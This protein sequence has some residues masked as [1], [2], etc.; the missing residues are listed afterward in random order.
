MN[1]KAKGKEGKGETGKLIKARQGQGKEE[2]ERGWEGQQIN[3]MMNDA[4]EDVM[5]N[6]KGRITNNISNEIMQMK[7]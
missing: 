2:R 7:D 6:E 5:N 4:Q 3:G 1:Q